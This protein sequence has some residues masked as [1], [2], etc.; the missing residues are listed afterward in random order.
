MRKRF[1][2][3]SL[4]ILST[5][6]KRYGLIASKAL[7]HF[8]CQFVP[9][10]LVSNRL[11]PRSGLFRRI[12]SHQLETTH[13]HQIHKEQMLDNVGERYPARHYVRVD[14]QLHILAAMKKAWEERLTTDDGFPAAGSLCAE[15]EDH[16]RQSARWVRARDERGL[17]LVRATNHQRFAFCSWFGP[18]TINGLRSVLGS[19]HEPST[20]CILF[21]VRA[22]NHQRFASCSWCEFSRTIDHLSR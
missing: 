4:V 9:L 2:D 14:D 12:P 7:G 8:L 16:R 13:S 18:R 17:F 1:G 11:S 15:S 19:R 21:L 5:S 10:L 22:T 20:V 6:A 3:L